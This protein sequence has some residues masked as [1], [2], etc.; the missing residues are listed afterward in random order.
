LWTVRAEPL[1]FLQS[2]K[3]LFERLAVAASRTSALRGRV[4]V[5][6]YHNIVPRGEHRAGEASLH[7][8]QD[9]FSRQ[10]DVLGEHL[11]VV[12]LAEAL[13]AADEPDARPRAVLTW[14][15]AYAGAVT[16]GVEEVT[17]RGFPATIFVAPAFLD[18]G[19]FWWDALA[20]EQG[21]SPAQRAVC[22][23]ECRG[24]Q[25][26]VHA[27]AIAERWPWHEPPASARG[28]SLADLKRATRLSGIHVGSHTWSHPNLTRAAP[29]ELVEELT[30]PREWLEQTFAVQDCPISYPYGLTSPAVESHARAAGYTAGLRIEGGAYRPGRDAL[31]ALPRYN[32]PAGLS[33]AGFELRL[34]GW[35]LR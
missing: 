19:T 15:D 28:A 33:L 29:D 31:L 32:V 10:L 24:R 20:S 18:G 34:R 21:V 9:A 7:L 5:L 6:A 30:R 26:I 25:E 27:R 4:L 16:A 17:R 2:A 22:L 23:E 3:S 12:S 1:R 13:T 8:P 11:K 14:D 35:L